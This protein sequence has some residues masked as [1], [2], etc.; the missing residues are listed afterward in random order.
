MV[1]SRQGEVAEQRKL[2]TILALDVSGYSRAAERDDS[3]AAESVRQL[4]KAI[5]EVAAPFGGRIFNSAGDGF[6]LEFPSAASGVQAAMALLKESQSGERP[7]PRIRIG[8]H[9]GDVI[10]EENGD[11][12]GNGV[13]V[14]ARLQALAEPGS[15]VVS[16]TVRAQVRSVAELP[17]TAHGRVQLDKMSERLAVYSLSPGHRSL[18]GG[19]ARRQTARAAFAAVILVVLFSSAYGAWRLLAGGNGDVVTSVS[20]YQGERESSQ[21]ALTTISFKAERADN[22]RLSIRTDFPYRERLQREHRL[23]G[24]MFQ[25]DPFER[26]LPVL[27]VQVTNTG[28]QTLSINEVQ[29]EV[30]RAEPDETPLPVVRESPFDLHRIVVLDAGWGSW[31]APRLAIE[32]W[33]LPEDIERARQVSGASVVSFEP[34]AR[35]TRIARPPPASVAGTLDVA[36]AVTFDLEGQ[37][38]DGFSD[39][40]FVCAI[41]QFTYRREGQDHRLDIRTRVSN[42][43]PTALAAS[44]AFS[45][46][47]LYL[48]P[49]RQ[50]YT[51]VVP[52]VREIRPGATDSFTLTVYTDR[53][54][55]FVLRHSVRTSTG[56]TFAGEQFDLEVVVPRQSNSSFVLNET[57]R[58]AVPADAIAVEDR[59]RLVESADF[60]P[61]RRGPVRF[62]LRQ[63][64]S[65][66]GCRAFLRDTAPLILRRAGIA[67]MDIEVTDP[68]GRALC[69][70]VENSPGH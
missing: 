41:G 9:L 62:R 50:N 47:D 32:A 45:V 40:L 14:A 65:I 44:P 46:Y 21:H 69:D 25:G 64:S 67:A 54:S 55:S 33:G 30:I 7:L 49:N 6:M 51:A 20:L 11:L 4:R 26:A 53:S 31:E 22:G 59:R 70:A 60:D 66:E 28:A 43:L 63:T 13:N 8:L 38:P 35:P 27:L 57:S 61:Q 2:A 36:G 19:I 29:F 34:C 5:A 39:A 68:N 18:F 42:R 3:A 15:A 23:D 52:V 48:D 1:A 16:E 24:L 17:F 56:T 10:V 37:F 12:L 58:M